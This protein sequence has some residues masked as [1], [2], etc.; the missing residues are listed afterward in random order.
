M[1]YM[2]QLLSTIDNTIVYPKYMRQNVIFDEYY[3]P[4]DGL[5]LRDLGKK[6]VVKVE[7]TLNYNVLTL[8]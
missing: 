8:S 3:W 5:N 4:T 7:K 2:K 6:I 1:N